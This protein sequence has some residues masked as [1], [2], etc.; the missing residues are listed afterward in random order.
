[1]KLSTRIANV[2]KKH[3]L[4]SYFTRCIF[5]LISF[6]SSSSISFQEGP[7]SSSSEKYCTFDLLPFTSLVPADEENGLCVSFFSS[8]L[9]F[10]C[11]SCI[12]TSLDAK[13]MFS[14]KQSSNH[15]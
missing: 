9:S 13:K 15:V 2:E 3:E 6:S 12:S 4:F 14:V 8:V 10:F 11:M 7:F 5:F 1:M